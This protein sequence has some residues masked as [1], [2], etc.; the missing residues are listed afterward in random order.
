M[1][2]FS[3]LLQGHNREDC[4]IMLSHFKLAY[5]MLDFN[6]N[7]GEIIIELKDKES[8]ERAKGVNGQ[9]CVLWGVLYDIYDVYDVF[10]DVYD[11]YDVFYDVY[12]VFLVLWQSNIESETSERRGEQYETFL[13]L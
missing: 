8:F 3:G 12:D 4:D 13:C 2:F 9:V 7:A 10:Y 5:R 6:R 11:I 1:G